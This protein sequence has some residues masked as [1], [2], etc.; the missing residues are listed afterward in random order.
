MCSRKHNFHCAVLYFVC[1]LC[2]IVIGLSLV[3]VLVGWC[4]LPIL[5]VDSVYRTVCII[6][7]L[8][9]KQNRY[10][11]VH[12]GGTLKGALQYGRNEKDEGYFLIKERVQTYYV[13]ASCVHILVHFNIPGYHKRTGYLF[14]KETSFNTSSTSKVNVLRLNLNLCTFSINIFLCLKIITI[15]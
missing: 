7:K 1:S 6:D 3:L 8:Y 5:N 9:I 2:S 15:L 4:V 12:F 14:K 10:E 13:N 11:N